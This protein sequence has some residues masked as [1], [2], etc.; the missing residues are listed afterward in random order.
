VVANIGYWFLL[1][2]AI[3][4]TVLV[5]K[6]GR[7]AAFAAV[8]AGWA[9]L[10]APLI[11]FGTPRFHVPTVVMLCIAAGTLWASL[12]ELLALP[13]PRSALTRPGVPER[14]RRRPKEWS[15]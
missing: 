12:A 4:G 14:S 5:W 11:T 9:M 6:R 15:S 13:A 3:P 8:L 10:A 2:S 1:V 7:G